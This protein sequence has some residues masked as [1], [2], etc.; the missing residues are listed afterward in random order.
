[1]LPSLSPWRR[2]LAVPSP[3]RAPPLPLSHT[4]SLIEQQGTMFSVR[5]A[6][7]RFF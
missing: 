1:L 6:T 2:A 7:S 4:L 3:T 5:N